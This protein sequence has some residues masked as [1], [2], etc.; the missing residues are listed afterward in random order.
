MFCPTLVD[1]PHNE[2]VGGVR[3]RQVTTFLPD[4]SPSDTVNYGYLSERDTSLSSGIL[5]NTPR[6]GIKYTTDNLKAVERFNLCNSMYDF[7]QTHIEYSHVREYRSAAG[8]TDYF[9]STYDDHPDGADT[10]VDK[11]NRQAIFGYYSNGYN[12]ERVCFSNPNNLVENLLTPF[13]SAQ[14]M[15]GLL[16]F[17]K[18]Y[19]SLSRDFCVKPARIQFYNVDKRFTYTAGG[20]EVC[21]ANIYTDTYTDVTFGLDLAST[22][23]CSISIADSSFSLKRETGREL[24]VRLQ[25]GNN[26]VKITFPSSAAIFEAD[27]WIKGAT[28]G[29]E[30]GLSNIIS[31]TYLLAL[32]LYGAEEKNISYGSQPACVCHR[33]SA[34]VAELYPHRRDA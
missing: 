29:H 34:A 23:T 18:K 1:L 7:T 15:R 21:A 4:G 2:N 17:M 19:K 28:N 6:Y 31:I 32:T 30:I 25:P 20:N 5:I 9:Y 24:V 27:L 26:A 12:D 11:E 3:V 8:Y 33:H 22:E 16:T 14:T 13:A 10:D